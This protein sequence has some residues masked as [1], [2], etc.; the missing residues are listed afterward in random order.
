MAR[1]SAGQITRNSRLKSVFLLDSDE[2]Q[3]VEMSDQTALTAHPIDI[4]LRKPRIG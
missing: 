1:V 3:G 4:P 2:S